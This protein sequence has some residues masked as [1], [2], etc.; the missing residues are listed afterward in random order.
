MERGGAAETWK[1]GHAAVEAN[2]IMGISKGFRHRNGSC[3][4]LRG[5]GA[6]DGGGV[7]AERVHVSL[8]R[9]VQRGK[10]ARGRRNVLVG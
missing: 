7:L 10:L 3:G 1:G 6:V 2:E 8:G 5:G 9:G 4:N